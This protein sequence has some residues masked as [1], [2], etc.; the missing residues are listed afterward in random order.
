MAR[1][2]YVYMVTNRRG[3]TLYVGVTSDLVRRVHEHRTH[4]TSGFT[5]RYNLTRLVWFETHEG[6][7]EAI[8][9]EKRLKHWLRDWKVALIEHENPDW[10]DLWQDLATP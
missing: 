2:A 7:M 5:D 6:P 4:A 3:G 8:R 10:R 9:R 1:Q